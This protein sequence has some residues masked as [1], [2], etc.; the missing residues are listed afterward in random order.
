MSSGLK[1]EVRGE[2]LELRGDRSLYWSAQSTLFVADL[3]WGKA[4]V[5]H[6]FGVGVPTT[7]L[8]ADLKRL[9]EALADSQAKRLVVLGDLVHN[10][11]HLDENLMRHLRAWRDS[12]PVTM[13]LV[14]GN[15]DRGRRDW[16]SAL[17]IEDWS[18]PEMFEGP[19][20]FIHDA[21]KC[22]DLYTWSG[23]IHPRFRA[24][25]AGSTLRAPCFVMGK[26]VGL[27]PAFSEFTAGVDVNRKPS[28][29]IFVVVEDQVIEV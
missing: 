6:R 3:H 22:S 19:F 2:M 24:D 25:F 23:H 7:V 20:R 15:H 13:V 21:K 9:G 29:R 18:S 17:S 8:D 26:T 12:R 1:V 5:F 28:E 27:L 11:R 14:P 10:P 16:L 4:E